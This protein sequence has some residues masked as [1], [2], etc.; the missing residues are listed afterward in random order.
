MFEQFSQFR[1]IWFV[2]FEFHGGGTGNKG[3]LPIPVCLAAREY[4]SGQIIRLWYDEFGSRPPYPTDKDSLFVAFYA[5]AELGC[6]IVLDWPMPQRILD[7]FVESRVHTNGR[8][9]DHDNSLIGV[10]AAHGLD[11]IGVIEK[12]EMRDLI[13][14]AGPWSVDE[15]VAI[16]DY[17][18]GDIDALA[19]L[20]PVMAPTI[21]LPR[22]LLRGRY[23]A[24]VAHMEHN[25]IPIDVDTLTSL[26]EHWD[27]IKDELIAAVDAD[28]QV[29]EGRTFKRSL[30]EAYLKRAGIPWLRLDSGELDTSSKAFRGSENMS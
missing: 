3:E 13:L 12:K 5:S 9:T 1:E 28:Y 27:G 17:C 15:I 30:F 26:Q 4:R 10:M 19:K 6:H 18:Q 14:T 7:L 21:D 23:M 2:D 25:G 29:F 20:L 8:L 22:A 16:L 11:S 24:A